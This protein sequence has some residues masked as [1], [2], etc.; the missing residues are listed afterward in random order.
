MGCGSSAFF[1]PASGNAKRKHISRGEV[2][3]SWFAGG[4]WGVGDCEVEISGSGQ[5]RAYV[6]GF[7]ISFSACVSED[8]Y[9]LPDFSTYG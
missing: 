6:G 8:R 5:K 7:F 4:D 1:I 9:R 2:Y 3:P